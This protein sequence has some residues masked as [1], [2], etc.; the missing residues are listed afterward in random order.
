MLREDD[1]L[2]S[3][4]TRCSFLSLKQIIQTQRLNNALQIMSSSKC[5]GTILSP[6]QSVSHDSV[7]FI[8]S[9]I[10]LNCML[11]F[12]TPTIPFFMRSKLCNSYWTE[13]K[14]CNQEMALV[15][16][17]IPDYIFSDLPTYKLSLYVPSA[18]TTHMDSHFSC[19]F[20]KTGGF[21]CSNFQ[22]RSVPD[23]LVPCVN[24][25]VYDLRFRPICTVRERLRQSHLFC[26]QHY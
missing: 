17:T 8:V 7:I 12:N 15:S 6:G 16:F 26:G 9:Q 18:D 11:E 22:R 19:L 5:R 24:V 10:I 25:V 1:T 13:I 2:I 20:T 4:S 3:S 23:N 14:I 21:S